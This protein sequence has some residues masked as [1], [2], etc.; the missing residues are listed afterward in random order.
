[1][2]FL[3]PCAVLIIVSVLTVPGLA[4][5][6]SGAGPST[7]QPPAPSAT[8]PPDQQN[9]QPPDQNGQPP[10]DQNAQPPA[11]QTPPTRPP[12]VSPGVRGG[13]LKLTDAVTVGGYGS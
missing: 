13:G 3:E 2:R 4:Q 11:Q 1:M 6:S 10:A 5:S 12:L 8:Q 9:A 7:A